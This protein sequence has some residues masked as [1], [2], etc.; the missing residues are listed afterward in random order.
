MHDL[1]FKYGYSLKHVSGVAKVYLM[2]CKSVLE[3]NKYS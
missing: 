3:L 1:N 2:E